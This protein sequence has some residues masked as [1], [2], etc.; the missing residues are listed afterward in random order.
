M[1]Y[2]FFEGSKRH[3]RHVS[4]FEGSRVVD[5]SFG[6]DA[7]AILEYGCDVVYE[8]SRG[9]A[10]EMTALAILRPRFDHRLRLG[11]TA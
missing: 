10:L 3:A 7:T 6:R 1:R 8:E 2:W 4:I 5:H 9:S 11:K